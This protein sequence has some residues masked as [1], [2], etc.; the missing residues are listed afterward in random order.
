MS[1]ITGGWGRLGQSLAIASREATR[2]AC[3]RLATSDDV[4]KQPLPGPGDDFHDA[5]A[6]PVLWWGT[7]S[8]R[9]RA[10]RK[11]QAAIWEGTLWGPSSQTVSHLPSGAMQPRSN[12]HRCQGTK[13]LSYPGLSVLNAMRAPL[14]MAYRAQGIQTQKEE[15]SANQCLV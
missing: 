3:R 13:T 7:D 12:A 2:L 15:R 4:R 14:H 1:E 9:L 5:M 10:V 6:L 8:G 11:L